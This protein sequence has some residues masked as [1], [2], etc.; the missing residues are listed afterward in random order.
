MTDIRLR[1]SPAPTG[2]LHIGSVRTALYN[3]LH[4]R[5]TRGTFLL[6]IEDTDVAR[7]T[8]E[9]IDQI[10][11]VLRWLGLH[12]DEGPYLQSHRFDAYLAAAQRLLDAGRAYECYCTEQEVR[13]RNEAAMKAGRPPGYDGRCR[14]LSTDQRAAL[15]AEGR[16]RSVRF[17]TPDDGRSTFTDVI[18]GEVSVEWSTI[19]DFVI[20]R[21]NGTPVF[22]LANALDDLDMNITHVL[23]GEDLIDSTHRVLALRRALGHDDQPVYAHMPLILGPGGGK[24]SKRHGAVSVEEYR[25]AGYLAAALLNYLALLGWGPEDGREVLT[26]DE[27]VREFDLARVNSS[28][29]TFDPKKLEWVNGEHIR[30]L[31][32]ADL[33]AAVLPFSRTRYGDR[34]DIPRFE[35]AVALAQERATTLVQIADQMAFLFCAD[36][37]LETDPQS[38][39]KL[40]R[41]EAAAAILDAVADAVHAAPWEASPTEVDVRPAIEALGLKP[42]K[43]MHVV[44]TAIQ[45]RSAGL[46]LFP[47]IA[48]LGRESSV[49]RLRAAH[50]RLQ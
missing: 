1:F 2:F 24:L 30:A 47:S 25:D 36:D 13:E 35:A 9:S 34:L 43:V 10:Q 45:G 20:V 23:R 38:W 29:A 42:G 49:R 39:E 17:R 44:Y 14:D 37:E 4:A 6:R 33:V 19:S 50:A 12:W 46:P 5:H 31:P 32:L 41:V 7:S 48:L 18:R 16:P 11:Q 40:T 27:L 26:V 3:W 21:S 15:A 22:F 8:Q 28:A